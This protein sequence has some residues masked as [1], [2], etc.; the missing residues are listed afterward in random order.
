MIRAA[1]GLIPLLALACRSPD[2]SHDS[3]EMNVEDS[4]PLVNPACEDAP[5]LR[6][7]N[8]GHGFLIENCN[9][10]HAA[11]ATERYGAP[12]DV[13]FDDVDEA[14]LWSAQ[15]LLAVTGEEA[16]MPP[17]GGVSEDDKQRLIWWLECAP[18]GT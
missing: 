18:E 4:I 12:E 3:R 10:C 11:T 15:I 2:P 17:E 16:T 13:H 7:N 5:A 9:G 1:L 14:W 8:F 6:Y